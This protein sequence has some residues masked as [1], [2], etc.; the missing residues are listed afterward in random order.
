MSISKGLCLVNPNIGHPIILNIDNELTRCDFKT[1]LLIITQIKDLN[2]VK[3]FLTDNIKL[4]WN[5]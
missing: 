1:D 3:E 2:K 4:G 5:I